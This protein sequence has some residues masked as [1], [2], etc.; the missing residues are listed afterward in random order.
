MAAADP[1][2]RVLAAWSERD[3]AAIMQSEADFR[4]AHPDH[5]RAQALVR[6]W[7]ERK[8]ADGRAPADP[9]PPNRREVPVQRGSAD[10]T[11]HVRA[12]TREGGQERVRA[13]TRCWPD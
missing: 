8:Y 2:E 11:V 10:R 5:A 9:M 4:S 7:F 12:R 6:T 1:F 13:H 3:I